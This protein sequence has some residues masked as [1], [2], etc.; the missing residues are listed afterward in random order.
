MHGVASGRR[1]SRLGNRALLEGRMMVFAMGRGFDERAA[2]KSRWNT[3][4]D[5]PSPRE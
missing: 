1:V 5:A 3:I 2:I 4:P